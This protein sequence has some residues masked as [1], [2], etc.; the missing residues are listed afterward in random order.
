MTYGFFENH[1]KRA[2]YEIVNRKLFNRQSK[3]LQSSHFLII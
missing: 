3:N 1:L 2:F